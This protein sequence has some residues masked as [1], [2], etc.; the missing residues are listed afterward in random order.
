M[1]I[2]P[3]NKANKRINRDID[4]IS[5]NMNQYTVQ[6]LPNLY[7]ENDTNNNN[8]ETNNND[9]NNETNNNN[10]NNNNNDTNNNNNNNICVEIITPNSNVISVTIPP[11]YPF[12]PPLNVTI[13]SKNYRKLLANMPTR[14][15]YLYYHPNDVYYNENCKL[16]HYSKP[17]C[18]C[19]STIMCHSNW[20]P[21]CSIAT[22]LHQMNQHNLL[23]RQISYRLLL[24]PGFEKNNLPL[25]LIRN[26]LQYL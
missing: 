26:V 8:N 12:R 21:A 24:K 11:E 3:N 13:N 5:K 6:I 19:C 9:T 4:Y 15:N 17:E 16:A 10:N 22:I 23:K 20:S 14:I 2:N 1:T 18:L 25:E 7:N